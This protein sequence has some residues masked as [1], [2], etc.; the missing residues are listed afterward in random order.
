M[1]ASAETLQPTP[2]RVV[3]LA[4]ENDWTRS[5]TA[6]LTRAGFNART[7]MSPESAV[8]AATHHPP[9]VLLLDSAHLEKGGLRVMEA[10][11]MAAPNM[12][13]LVIVDGGDEQLRL[14]SFL[15]GADDCIPRPFAVQEAVVRVR[16]AAERR[17]SLRRLESENLNH[18]GKVLEMRGEM[19]ELRNTLRRN[20][21][22]LQQGVDLY[23]RLESARGTDELLDGFLRNLSAQ[24]GIR[25]LGFLGPVDTES[26]WWSMRASRGIP[27]SLTTTFRLPGN[28]RFTEVMNAAAGPVILDRLGPYPGT[29]L[30]TGLLATGGFTVSAPLR[31]RGRLLGMLLLGEGREG[32]P[33]DEDTRNV[34]QFLLSAL[35]P[36]INATVAR[37]ADSRR[38]ANRLGFLVAQL[39]DRDPYLRGHSQRVARLAED[40]GR[41]LD[42]RDSALS[43]LV[44]SAVLHDVGRFEVDAALWGKTDPLSPADWE[45]IRRH[46]VEGEMMAAETSWPD[47]VLRAIRHHHERWDGAGYPDG[48]AGESIPLEA[49]ILA[50]ADTFEALT[51]PRA[52]RPALTHPD[53]LR[54]LQQEAGAKLD[55]RLVAMVLEAPERLLLA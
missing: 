41:Q 12:A 1:S 27:D 25:R 17:D 11:R 7:V 51:S 50:V 38:H 39:E 45:L 20:L 44:S 9:A 47:D 26:T 34:V 19:D 30:E 28:G 4:P 52:Y 29:A 46:P 2:P 43:A 16:R 53:A 40:L 15:L 24:T 42:Y 10:F 3:V 33:P 55:P 5:I 49:R 6:S 37:D 48:L 14:K 36:A 8:L 13:I 23:Q 22:R 31:S 35:A 18:R 32:G 21:G 54:T